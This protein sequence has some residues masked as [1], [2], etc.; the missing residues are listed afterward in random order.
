MS[1][2]AP[3][4]WCKNYRSRRYLTINPKKFCVEKRKTKYADHMKDASK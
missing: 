3:E 1:T 4:G 2:A